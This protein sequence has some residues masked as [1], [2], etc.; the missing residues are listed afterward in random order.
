MLSTIVIKCDLCSTILLNSKRLLQIEL[1]PSISSDWGIR[2]A[3][4]REV[5]IDQCLPIVGQLQVNAALDE[6]AGFAEANNKSMIAVAR[7]QLGRMGAEERQ[8]L[9]GLYHG[10]AVSSSST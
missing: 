2:R 8:R 5:S 1:L 10:V 7:H 9:H 6:V 4:P 3:K